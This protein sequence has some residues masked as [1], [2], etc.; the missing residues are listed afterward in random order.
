MMDYTPQITRSIDISLKD[1][2]I[3]ATMQP[4][5]AGLDAA[6]VE[7][8]THSDPH[9]WPAIRVREHGGTRYLLIDGF[10]RLAAAKQMHLTTLRADIGPFS[11]GIADAFKLNQGHG[12]ALTLEDR[13]AHARRLKS[14]QPGLS[15][16]AIARECGLSDHTVKAA[17]EGRQPGSKDARTDDA[18]EAGAILAYDPVEAAIDYLVEAGARG[19]GP[20]H[21]R[22]RDV[23]SAIALYDDG[24]QPKVARVLARW[25]AAFLEAA[26]SYGMKT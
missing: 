9:D 23:R 18:P 1:I 20:V 13:K 24:D 2:V 6:H 12:K 16:I 11:G 26:Q 17:I 22:V 21:S 15:Y 5:T 7:S 3:D 14:E 8:L 10:H 19:I 25:G 4:R